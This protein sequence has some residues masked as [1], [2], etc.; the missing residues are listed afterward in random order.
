MSW[1]LTE[2]KQ[3]KTEEVLS[4][5]ISV[6]EAQKRI[7]GDFKANP[8]EN[9]AIQEACGSVLSK[10]IYAP[11]DLPAYTNSAMDGFAVKSED[12]TKASDQTPILLKVVMDIPAG[13]FPKGRVSSGEA[14]RIMTGAPLPEGTDAVIPFEETDS[15]PN[16]FPSVISVTKPARSGNYVRYKG[17][18]V[19][20]GEAILAAGR[21]LQ[22]QD[23]G[24][25]ASFGVSRVLVHRKPLIAL[26]SSGDELVMLG[27]ALAPGQ[28]YE[29]NSMMIA[30]S[31]L[32]NKGDVITIGFVKDD[33]NELRAGLDKA[34]AHDVDLIIT[35]AGASTGSYDYLKQ[36]L[37]DYGTLEFSRINMR[38]GKPVTYG[39]YQNT[40]LIGLPGNPVSCFVGF[41]VFVLPL[42]QIL[43]GQ[44]IHRRR[45]VRA[46][47]VDPI[48]SDGRE[49]YLRAFITSENRQ[50][51]AHIITHQGSG[52]ILSLVRSN[53]LLIIPSGVKSLPIGSKVQAWLVDDNLEFALTGLQDCHEN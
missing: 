36:I 14:A 34:A 41:M 3:V 38:P 35:T 53:A 37:L 21:E 45:I 51:E 33:P 48:D 49:S 28:I 15:D 44:N 42:L 11:F 17:Q 20:T 8:P 30:A 23:I 50:L 26:L 43:S 29:S 1:K 24:L 7:F 46:T 25:L 47:L 5:L 40:P 32:K 27:H 13:I 2:L 12:I 39:S 4:N 18:D 10:M 6:D 31:I 16:V 22:P 9:K 52:N 19:K